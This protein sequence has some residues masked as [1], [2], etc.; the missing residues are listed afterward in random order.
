M[1]A[2][3]ESV[4]MR[5]LALEKGTVVL[6]DEVRRARRREGQPRSYEI[7]KVTDRGLET[8][9]SLLGGSLALPRNWR[10]MSLMSVSSGR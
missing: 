9:K 4:A 1:T 7:L 2:G 10:V 8:H 3:F 5:L 6:A